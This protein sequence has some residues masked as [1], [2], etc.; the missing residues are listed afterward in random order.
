MSAAFISAKVFRWADA[1]WVEDF[2]QGKTE[3]WICQ[4]AERAERVWKF[5]T[6]IVQWNVAQTGTSSGMAV[7]LL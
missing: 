4:C 5:P 2:R 6:E 3:S 7:K 1:G